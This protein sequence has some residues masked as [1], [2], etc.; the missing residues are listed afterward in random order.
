M[1]TFSLIVPNHIED[2]TAYKVAFYG[3]QPLNMRYVN[4]FRYY[5]SGS[6]FEYEFVRYGSTKLREM[7]I[8]K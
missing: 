5:E 3:V 1:A 4:S 2:E 7:Q 6:P 8:Q